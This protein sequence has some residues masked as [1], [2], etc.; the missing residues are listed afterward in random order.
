M[1]KSKRKFI[2]KLILVL[3][4]LGVIF[5]FS[6]SNGEETGVQS[7]SITKI[8]ITYTLKLTN[9]INI[10][11]IDLSNEETINKIVD[12][13]HPF[14]RKL[15]HFTEYF[16][17]AILVLILVKETTL[18]KKYLFVILFCICIA[19]WDEI[20]QLLISERQGRIIDV[21]IDTTGC[22]AYLI[23]NKLFSIIKKK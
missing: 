13:Y 8:A 2:I 17:L 22:I 21:L 20:H 4:W 10:T 23:I 5:F 18:D 7:Q 1:I 16:I 14:I 3:L 19:T 12:E 9:S 6:N 11:N 15:A